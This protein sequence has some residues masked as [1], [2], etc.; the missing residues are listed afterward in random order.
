MSLTEK[1]V[2]TKGKKI[3]S[4]RWKQEI[5]QRIFLAEV[6]LSPIVDDMWNSNNNLTQFSLT[7]FLWSRR[8]TYN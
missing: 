5:V 3:Y 1:E 6:I 2:R 8:P 4:Y 7:C